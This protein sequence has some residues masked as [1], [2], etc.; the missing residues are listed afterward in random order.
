MKLPLGFI[1][2]LLVALPDARLAN[3]TLKSTD[4]LIKKGGAIGATRKKRGLRWR[5]APNP[6]SLKPGGGGGGVAVA[7]KDRARPPPGE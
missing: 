5:H 3:L 7:Y 4:G 2:P 6:L 1:P